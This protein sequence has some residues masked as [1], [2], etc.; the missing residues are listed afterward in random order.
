MQEEGGDKFDW[1]Q[2]TGSTGTVNTGPPND[3]TYG[4]A[5]GMSFLIF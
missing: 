5:K 4:T 2:Q 1:T 3:H